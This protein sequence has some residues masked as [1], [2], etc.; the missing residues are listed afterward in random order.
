MSTHT[1]VLDQPIDSNVYSHTAWKLDPTHSA[2]H[3]GIRHMVGR[4]RGTF[5]V[6]EGTLQQGD[7]TLA[8]SVLDVVIDAASIN[9]NAAD[10]DAHLRSAD[11]FD[12]TNYPTMTFHATEFIPKVDGAIEIPGAL[13]IRGTTRPVTLHAS[14][15]G[16]AKDPWG[17]LRAGFEATTTINRSDFGLTWN[18]ALEA[19]GFLV[20]EKVT[21][22]LEAEFVWQGPG[23][24]N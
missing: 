11:F 18:A 12:A 2:V 6:T 5:A 21:I 15:G 14:D 8:G 3:F 10:R 1:P 23:S 7:P 16:R 9:T 17:N 19:G 20:G 22:T 24:S 4:V 13:T